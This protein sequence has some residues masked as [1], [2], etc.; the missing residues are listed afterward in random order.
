MA[1]ENLELRRAP[2]LVMPLYDGTLESVIDLQVSRKR[3]QPPYFT[4]REFLEMAG[5]MLDVVEHL[6]EHRFVHNDVK[7]DNWLYSTLR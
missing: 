1:R 5:Q 4:A 3:G 2:V 6:R 7:P